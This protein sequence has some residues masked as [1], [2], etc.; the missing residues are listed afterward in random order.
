[1]VT[2]PGRGGSKAADAAMAL[3]TDTKEVTLDDLIEIINKMRT[4]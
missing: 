2:N 3:L 1:M 4:A